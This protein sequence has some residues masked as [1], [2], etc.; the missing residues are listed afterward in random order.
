MPTPEA[1]LN[2]SL[3]TIAD[4]KYALDQADIVAITDERGIINYVNDNFCNISGYSAHEL[5]GKDHRIINSKHHPKE[6]FKNLWR[7]ISSGNVWKGEIKNKAKSGSF[8]WVDTTIVPFL[9][10]DGKPYQYLAIRHD[11]TKQKL[12]EE[13]LLKLNQKLEA[14]VIERTQES[15]DRRKYFTALIENTSDGIV[16]IDRTGKI[17][18][19]NPAVERI[20]GYA[21]EEI[22]NTFVGQYFHPDDVSSFQEL[23]HQLGKTPGATATRQYRLL[24]KSG[25]YIWVEGTVCNRIDDNYIKAYIINYRDITERKNAETALL[26]SKQFTES[27]LASLSSHIAVIDDK[28]VI[29]AVN[30]AWRN[31]ADANGANA[32]LRSAVGINYFDACRKAELAGDTTA[33][34]ALAGMKSVL[35]GEAEIFEFRYP[36]H[37]NTEERWFTLRV[38]K[39]ASAKPAIVVA[40][41]DITAT[42]KA[43]EN[44]RSVTQQIQQIFD[45]LDYSFWGADIKQG[46]MQYLSPGTKKVYGY[47]IDAF[48]HNPRLYY[49]VVLPEDK[50]LLD[51][52][53][54]ILARGEKASTE[55]RIRHKD[56]SIRWLEASMIPTIDE[57]GR[58]VR[59]DG[60]CIDITERREAE[61]KFL[62]SQQ[63]FKLLIEKSFDGIGLVNSEGII[64]YLSPSGY[65]MLGYQPG[66]LTGQLVVGIIH[67]DDVEYMLT[68]LFSVMNKPGNTISV[69]LRMKHK[70]GEWRWMEGEG[71]NMIDEPAIGALVTNFRDITERKLAEDEIKELNESLEKKVKERTLELQELNKDME[72]F[73]Y[74]VAHDLRAPLRVIAGFA[75]LLHKEHEQQFDDDAKQ[76]IDGIIQ[77]SKRMSHL[78]DDL[79]QFARLG[80]VV[81]H[82]AVCN[83][84]EQ[85]KEVIDFMKQTEAGKQVKFEIHNLPESFCDCTLIKQVWY[86]LISNAVKYSSKQNN[87]IVEVGSQLKDGAVIYY[88]KDNGT[89]FDM[90]Y[91]SKLFQAFQRLHSNTEY[92]GTGIGL[93]TVHRII[94]KHGGN[95]WAEAEPGKGATFY[96]TLPAAQGEGGSCAL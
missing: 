72:S 40:H 5:I 76:L 8:Y 43:E 50:H 4:Y 38:M 24:H 62:L 12:V 92:E 28:G 41:Q 73:N 47:E 3:K 17:T 15:E 31:F 89:G 30:S 96:F 61:Q 59:L 19:Q 68:S 77:N 6:F 44:Y 57:E 21:A 23:M 7:T 75:G 45:T 33:A 42:V 81:A 86:N 67:P 88:V 54:P 94:T 11:I 64:T 35:N 49:D 29:L 93:A 13:E 36:C 48:M 70:N 58:F 39:F 2:R 79:L 82:P 9:D 63:R 26:E 80:K 18:Y 60:I 84:N 46:R 87:A 1:K 27:I 51:A 95:V 90:A 66:E 55:Y 25:N 37:S 52:L 78:I 32:A 74:T 65:R 14:R 53:D 69:R 91:A 10:A 56:G 83:M 16:L 34:Q 20:G 85:V 22:E 71:S